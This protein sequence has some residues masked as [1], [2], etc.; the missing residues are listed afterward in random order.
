MLFTRT[1][2]RLGKLKRY[3]QILSKVV[4]YGF[5]E[6]SDALLPR[7]RGRQLPSAPVRLRRLGSGARLRLLFE[8]LGPTFIKF[9]Q[10]L[11]LRPDLLPGDI[12]SELAKLQYGAAPLPLERLEPVL[13][14]ELGPAWRELFASFEPLPLA[15][16]S[17]A[18]VHRAV[19]REG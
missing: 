4:F 8:E 9:G 17:I 13:A 14:A 19:T 6:V 18:Q 7:R 12:I 3:R 1:R 16:A 10:F 11:S 2:Q 5:S 15:S